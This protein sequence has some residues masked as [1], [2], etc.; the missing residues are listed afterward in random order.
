MSTKLEKLMF[1][2]NLQ[3]GVTGPVG[4]MQKQLDD[5]AGHARKSFVQIG[6]GAAGIWAAGQSM[7]Y[8]LTPAR[9]MNKALME[10]SSLDVEPKALKTLNREALAF[11]I[12]FGESASAV[13]S[14]AYD[15]QSSIAGLSG[16]ELSRFTVSSNVLAKATKADAAT[17][18][19]Y[20]GTMYGIF[21]NQ[22]N[23]MGKAKWVEQLT[24]QTATAV[25]MF[26]TT[27]QEMSS[28]FTSLGANATAAGI[29]V[30]EQM[31][32]MGTLQS[33]MSGSEA[34]TKYKAFLSGVGNAQQQ[35]GLK[36][37]DAN[38]NMLGMMDIL[39]KLKGKFGDSFDVAE[40]DTLKKAFGSDEAVSLI[41]LLMADT[42]GLGA[43]I[44]QLGKV[45]GMDKATTMAGRMVDPFDRA[46]QG[47][48][49]LITVVGQALLPSINPL[50]DGFT[51]VTATMVRWADMFPNLTRWVGYGIM[52]ILGFGAVLGLA[53]VASGVA[54][55]SMFGLSTVM[56]P[57]TGTLGLMRKAWALY[58]GAQWVANAAMWGFP[59]TW[60]VMALVAL[61]AAVGA[62]IWWWDDLK[63]AF[64]DTSWGQAIMGVIDQVA[65]VFKWYFDMLGRMWGW[66]LEKVQA[67]QKFLGMDSGASA[68][69]SAPAMLEAPRSAS[70]PAGGVTQSISNAVSKNSSNSRTIQQV[71]I[72]TS[73]PMD[74]QSM[75][76]MAFMAAG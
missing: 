33:T 70:V 7:D 45:Q 23:D 35:L 66:V 46:T 6:T 2:I 27:G 14:S 75:S 18:T 65:G 3:D 43:S 53:S 4:K 71:N 26:K 20:V 16:D 1:A 69:V 25:Q 72:T 50:V 17:I 48:N 56:G 24:G 41:K 52:L 22:A 21:K 63:A 40:S 10:V 57:I 38:G 37:T 15:I 12:R 47:V 31:A 42:K 55:I 59:G 74:A 28:A 19:S 44:D 32:I 34:G 49:A 64:L 51:D 5:L 54:R 62:V 73:K 58:S 29:D 60:I 9:Q 67:V 76:E 11:S 8:M 36:F 39:D 68:E 61:V 13:A 30:A